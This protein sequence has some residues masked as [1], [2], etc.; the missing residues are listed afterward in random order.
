MLT[1]ADRCVDVSM[2]CMVHPEIYICN[3]MQSCCQILWYAGMLVCVIYCRVCMCC[4]YDF[5]YLITQRLDTRSVSTGISVLY[6]VLSYFFSICWLLSLGSAQACSFSA[7]STGPVCAFGE[8]CSCRGR[9]NQPIWH[10]RTW[11]DMMWRL[12]QVT[13]VTSVCSSQRHILASKIL[14]ARKDEIHA[15]SKLDW[16]EDSMNQSSIRDRQSNQW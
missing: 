6:V 15:Q 11:S 8:G 3:T 7:E 14:Q 12:R 10:D 4:P 16:R 2:T 5:M 1:V 13:C 9:K